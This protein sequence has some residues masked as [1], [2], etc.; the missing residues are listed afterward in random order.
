MAKAKVLRASGV[1]HEGRHYKQGET[2]DFSDA[3]LQ[4]HR[5]LAAAGKVSASED[6]SDRGPVSHAPRNAD[7]IGDRAKNISEVLGGPVVT[8]DNKGQVIGESLPG[9]GG[10]LSAQSATDTTD[11]SSSKKSKTRKK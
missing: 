8:G 1:V 9:D 10:P 6:E 4:T 11:N 5:N 3:H 7:D 2:I